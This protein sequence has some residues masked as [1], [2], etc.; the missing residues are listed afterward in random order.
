MH[1]NVDNLFKTHAHSIHCTDDETHHLVNQKR[2]S[3]MPKAD[4]PNL[5]CVNHVVNCA[6]SGIDEDA[7]GNTELDNCHPW[8]LMSSNTFQL[9]ASPLLQH[10]NFH[11][12]RTSVLPPS[13]HSD[14]SDWISSTLFSLS[15]MVAWQKLP[16]IEDLPTISL[17]RCWGS[18]NVSSFVVPAL[19]DELYQ[20]DT[21]NKKSK[22]STALALS[23]KIDV[24][25]MRCSMMFECVE[26][27]VECFR[28]RG[29]S[30]CFVDDS[31]S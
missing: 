6:M 27:Q 14:V 30:R 25:S 17:F 11:G 29:V 19:W 21:R 24:V 10:Q 1:K 28:A 12:T 23:M 16:S 31:C 22:F 2:I 8:P 4:P 9:T 15:W 3:M 20:S 18:H 7:A 5:Q 26:Q 13:K